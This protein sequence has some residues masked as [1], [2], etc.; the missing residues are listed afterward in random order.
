RIV[1][2]VALHR[3]VGAVHDLDGVMEV[4]VESNVFAQVARA[5]EDADPGA[6]PAHVPVAHGNVL[7]VGR[8]DCIVAGRVARGQPADL[9][10]VAVDG[11]VVGGDGD[12]RSAGD[13]GAQVLLQAPRALGG[14]RGGQRIDEAGAVVVALGGKGAARDS[15]Q[16]GKE[17]ERR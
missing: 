6:E 9:E 8:R 10:I 1:D 3:A 13:R 11:D 15:G 5:Y 17:G 16:P 12:G 14:D 2:P 7:R 4:V